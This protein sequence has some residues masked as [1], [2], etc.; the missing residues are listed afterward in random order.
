VNGALRITRQ[1]LVDLHRRA[2]RTAV[3]SA[4]LGRAEPGKTAL[5]RGQTALNA[6]LRELERAYPEDRTL[7]AAADRVRRIYRKLPPEDRRRHLVMFYAPDPEWLWWRSLQL[8]AGDRIVWMDRPYLRPL[9]AL[10]ESAPPVGVVSVTQGIV[11]L[12]TWSQGVVEEATPRK[13]ALADEDWRRYAGPAPSHPG[14]MQQTSTYVDKYEDRVE[15]HL[16]RFLAEVGGEVAEV[17]EREGWRRVVLLGAPALA[18]VLAGALAEPWRSRV[19][20][21]PA[22][23]L[24]KAPAAA[25]AEAV[26]GVVARW[27]QD[28]DDRAVADL[29][30]VVAAGAAAA[31]GAQAC[32]DFLAEGRVGHLYL[33]EQVRLSGYRRPDGAIIVDRGPPPTGTIPE[34]HLVERMIEMAL[35]QGV[36]VTLVRG[37]AAERLRAAGGVGAR[38]RY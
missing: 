19:L 2:P 7:A 24:T 32:V 35:D 1:E 15:V 31:T 28:R 36:P 37:A 18:G 29:L 26:T 23:N 11:R 20:A 21:G 8:E 38:L 12:L 17:G 4:Y 5:R 27:I 22:V 34:R 9:V 13:F 3:L 30:D 6:G 14:V 16:R 25:L 33:D 10:L